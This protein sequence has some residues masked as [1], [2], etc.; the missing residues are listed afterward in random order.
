MAT[1]WGYTEAFGQ[2]SDEL[3]KVELDIIDN[4]VC[5]GFMEGAKL[6]DGIISSQICAGVLAGKKDTCAGGKQK[7]YNQG[8]KS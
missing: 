1:G 3:M 5:N 8:T 4:Q 6:D 7:F 2:T